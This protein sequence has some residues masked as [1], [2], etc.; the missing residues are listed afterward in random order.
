MGKYANASYVFESAEQAFAR[1]EDDLGMAWWQFNQGREFAH[2]QNDCKRVIPQLDAAL[3][4]LREKASSRV[5][6]EALLT[7][8]DAHICE[9]NLTRPRELLT[10]VRTLMTQENP[11]S[12]RPHRS[13]PQA[14][15]APA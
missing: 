4:V 13:L 7:L 15:L 6:I 2:D 1:A 3:P 8:A 14:L 5:A 11:D 9:G 12:H 10:E